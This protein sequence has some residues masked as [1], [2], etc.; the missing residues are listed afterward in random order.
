MQLPTDPVFA[1]EGMKPVFWE[2]L[3]SVF[4][5][6]KQIYEKRILGSSVRLSVRPSFCMAQL[7]YY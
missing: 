7:N 2:I 1:R 6:V 3:D 5:L 4:R